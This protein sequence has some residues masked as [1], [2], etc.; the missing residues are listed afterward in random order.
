VQG[1]KKAVEKDI[2]HVEFN[3]VSD[4]RKR[5]SSAISA[6][7]GAVETVFNP[8]ARRM[9]SGANV[10]LHKKM[11]KKQY[12]RPT[13]AMAYVALEH[14]VAVGS[15]EASVKNKEAKWE[16]DE[17]LGDA[18]DGSEGGVYQTIW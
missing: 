3:I 11:N 16:P 7:R 15:L 12:T 6:I 14:A 1:G 5:K 10:Y 18:S 17:I 4:E 13:A 2:E 9:V 8:Y